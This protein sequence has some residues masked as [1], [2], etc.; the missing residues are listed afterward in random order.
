[1]EPELFGWQRST[2]W[3]GRW[4][5]V[6]RVCLVQSKAHRGLLQS[7][8]KMGSLFTI[9]GCGRATMALANCCWCALIV[10][11]LEAGNCLQ[12]VSVHVAVTCVS[13]GTGILQHLLGVTWGSVFRAH[14]KHEMR[15]N[16]DGDDER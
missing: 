12:W 11:L 8:I 15:G 14:F 13:I 1:M 10:P 5:L 6:L 7:R 9:T 3:L 2:G 4:G 16:D